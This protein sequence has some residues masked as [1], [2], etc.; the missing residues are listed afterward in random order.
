MVL[1]N[2]VH[3]VRD[4]LEKLHSDLQK[5]IDKNEDDKD[6]LENRI[7]VIE[8]WR[9]QFVA[10]FS[11]YAAIALFLGSVAGQLLIHIVTTKFL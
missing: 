6:K 4:S 3:H 11:V 9:I 2:E 7:R 10:K 8:D 1:A 5:Y